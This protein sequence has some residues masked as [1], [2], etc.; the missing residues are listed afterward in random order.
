MDGCGAES[1]HLVVFD[2]REGRTWDER[3]FR[4]APEADG[5]PVTVWGV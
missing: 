3:V 2:L 5:P 1:G 4:R